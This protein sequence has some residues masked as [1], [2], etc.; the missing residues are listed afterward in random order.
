MISCRTRRPTGFTLIELTL[1]TFIGLAVGAM[2]LAVVNQQF[3]F[4]RIYGA[5]SFLSEEAPIINSYISKLVSQASRY[6]LHN[7]LSQALAGTNMV[8]TNAPVIL[9]NF[10]QPDGTQRASILAYQDLGSG[11]ALYYYVVPASGSVSTPQWIVT[12][13]PTNIRFSIESGVLRVRLT[14]PA[15]EEIIYSGNMQR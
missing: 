11:P 13:R 9:L 8:M 15:G 14:G 1:A 10:Q 2:T 7:N 3:A 12:R 5:Q 4:L 6:R